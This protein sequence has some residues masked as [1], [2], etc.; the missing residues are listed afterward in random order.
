M[1]SPQVMHCPTCGAEYRAGYTLCT[2]DYTQLVAGP[3]PEPS[4]PSEPSDSEDQISDEEPER[5]PAGIEV[6]HRGERSAPE[7]GDVN[8][9]ELDDLFA[10]EELMPERVVLGLLPEEEAVRPTR[11]GTWR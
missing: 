3:A 7:P 9:D 1:S 5:Q 6:V 8:D 10:Q 2:D 4:E 11:T